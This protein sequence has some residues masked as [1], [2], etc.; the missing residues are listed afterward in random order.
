MVDLRECKAKEGFYV[1]SRLN[2]ILFIQNTNEFYYLK[3]STISMVIRVN[4]F[5]SHFQA[6]IDSASSACRGPLDFTSEFLVIIGCCVLGLIWAFVN[7]FLVSK[8]NVAKG[9]TGFEEDGRVG[10]DVTDRQKSLL[11][12]LGEKISTV[13]IHLLRELMSF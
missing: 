2:F 10:A 7:M 8:V 9:I 1:D 11:I 5:E 6:V 3:L 12:E 4:H 13:H